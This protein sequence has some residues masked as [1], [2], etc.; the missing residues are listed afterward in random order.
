VGAGTKW[1]PGGAR[2]PGAGS[3]RLVDRWMTA[4]ALDIFMEV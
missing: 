2:K 1:K 4:A 3:R